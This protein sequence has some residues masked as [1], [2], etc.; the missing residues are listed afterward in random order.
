[1]TTAGRRTGTR[2]KRRGTIGWK[3]KAWKKDPH[4]HYCRKRLANLSEA[5]VDHKKPLALGGYSKRTNYVLA[6]PRCNHSKGATPYE[7]FTK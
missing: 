6:C 4:C 7:E 1:M 3:R 2:K 5:S